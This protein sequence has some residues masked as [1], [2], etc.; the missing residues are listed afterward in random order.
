VELTNKRIAITGLGV[1][2]PLGNDVKTSWENLIAGKSAIAPITKFDASGFSTKIAAEVKNFNIKDYCKNKKLLRYLYLSAQFA[3][4]AATEALNDAGV[5]PE[6]ATA[7]NWGFVAG[8][9]QNFVDFK[10]FKDL[11]RQVFSNKNIDVQNIF[12]KAENFSSVPCFMRTAANGT[13]GLLTNYFNIKGYVN[14]V[15]TACASGGQAL[16][17]ATSVLRR[18]D[19]DYMLVGG[20]DSMITPTGLSGFCL[21]GALSEDNDNCK[22]ASRPFDFTRSGFILGEGAAFM[23]LEP[24]DKAVARGAKIYAEIAGEGNSLSSYRIT[25]S[26]P[27][28]DG[29]IQSIQGALKDANVSDDDIKEV[30][31]TNLIGTMQVTQEV[32]PYMMKQRAGKIINISSVSAEKGGRGQA[33][34][35]ASKGAVNAMTKSL[36]V[37]LAK[38]NI[39]VNAVAPGIIET[40]ISEEVRNLAGEEILNK[41]LVKRYGQAKEVAYLVAFLASKYADYINGEILHIDGGFK[42]N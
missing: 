6:N 15:H 20:Y 7:E 41:I 39:T 32:V 17:L 31:N 3:L 18:G 5:K 19:V 9:G 11:Y 27:S 16:G 29:A 10:D 28:G 30:I 34:Y 25:D 13:L 40:D 42:M 35:A 23:V 21:L 33:N 24:W 1:V 36:A 14:A 4:A 2:S 12:A 37:E 38:R 26:H 8:S 22:R